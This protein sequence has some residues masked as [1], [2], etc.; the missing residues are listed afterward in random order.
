MFGYCSDIVYGSLLTIAYF[1]SF[2]DCLIAYLFHPKALWPLSR[3]AAY[4]KMV[5][6]VLIGT[7]HIPVYVRSYTLAESVKTVSNW[8][9]VF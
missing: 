7:T 9:S 8:N 5:A 6:T 1:K 2:D 4:V 3:S